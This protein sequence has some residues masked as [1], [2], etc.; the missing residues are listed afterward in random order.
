MSQFSP[1]GLQWPAPLLEVQ[2]MPPPHHDTPIRTGLN[3]WLLQGA[4]QE[5][6]TP[7]W[8]QLRA[9]PHAHTPIKGISM[10]PA[11]DW[12]L[13]ACVVGSLKTAWTVTSRKPRIYNQTRSRSLC[14]WECQDTTLKILFFFLN[15]THVIL[16]GE[17]RG[18]RHSGYFW[19]LQMSYKAFLHSFFSNIKNLKFI[20]Q[21]GQ[22]R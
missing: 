14:Q 16:P 22:I 6:H 4:L 10:S 7:A 11:W 21:S 17:R 3:C 2:E 9:A 18:P 20:I 19:T 8:P 5:A 13:A 12:P 1:A 15:S